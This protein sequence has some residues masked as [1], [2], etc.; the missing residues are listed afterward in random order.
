MESKKKLVIV[1]SGGLIQNVY[2]TEPID[3][4]AVIDFDTSDNN[5][6]QEAVSALDEVTALEIDNKIIKVV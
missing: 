3:E 4:I 2:F 1:V 5:E 6:Y